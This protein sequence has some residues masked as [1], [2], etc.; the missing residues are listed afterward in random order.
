MIRSRPVNGW[1]ILLEICFTAYATVEFWWKCTVS[2]RISIETHVLVCV[3]RDQ[4]DYHGGV[5]GNLGFEKDV[6]SGIKLLAGFYET[7]ILT[8]PRP[9]EVSERGALV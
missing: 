2:A 4:P 5:L 3:F 9:V 6:V 7:G 8:A 1:P